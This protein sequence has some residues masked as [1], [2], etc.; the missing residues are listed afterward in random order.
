MPQAGPLVLELGD[1]GAL[2]PVAQLEG[3]RVKSGQ[4]RPHAPFAMARAVA[5]IQP[6]ADE[7]IIAI[8]RMGLVRASI[9]RHQQPAEARLVLQPVA[10]T[11]GEFAART[12]GSSWTHEGEA[13]FLLYHHPIFEAAPVRTPP[14][15]VIAATADGARVVHSFPGDTAYAVYPVSADAWLAQYRSDDGERVATSYALVTASSGASTALTQLAFEKQASPLS[16][17]AAP[18]SLRSAAAGLSGPLL[19]EARF[20]DGSRRTYVRGDPAEASPAWGQVAETGTGSVAAMLVTDD[21][22]VSIATGH[23]G[24]TGGSAKTSQYDAPVAEARV[25]DAALVGG[26]IVA[27]WEE[28]LF[29]DIGASGIMV[30]DPGL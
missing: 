26:M 10:Q 18:P 28:D 24:E 4:P 17:A 19:I 8:N 16:I 13:F 15:I 1:D 5:A 3:A 12:V 9:Q 2:A 21:W 14:S 6:R 29:P 25:R 23:D 27:V 11:D 20:P 7:G 22:R 30:I